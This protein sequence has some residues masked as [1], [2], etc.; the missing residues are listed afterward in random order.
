VSHLGKEFQT[1]A[2]RHFKEIQDAYDKLKIK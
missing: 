1:L 2:E